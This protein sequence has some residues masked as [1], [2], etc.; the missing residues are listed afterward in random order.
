MGCGSCARIQHWGSPRSRRAV[1]ALE[2]TADAE[3]RAAV[4]VE[5]VM[6]ELVTRLG[7]TEDAAAA[8]V[9]AVAAAMAAEALAA[10]V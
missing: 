4:A 7:V 3:V 5:A 2:V 10:P 1:E 6:A 9:P 8:A